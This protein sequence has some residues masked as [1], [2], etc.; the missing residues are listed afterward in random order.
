[1]AEAR[2]HLS[3]LPSVGES[4]DPQAMAAFGA[5]E[6]CVL[7]AEGMPAEALAAARRALSVGDQVGQ[8][9]WGVKAAFQE[10][11]EAALELGDSG[12]ARDLL[13]MLDALAPGSVAPFLLAQRA[14]FH[15][16][17]GSTRAGQNGFA[18]AAEILRELG[19]PFHHA[20]V[21]LEH[22]E[23]LEEQERAEDAAPLREE[24]HEAF[25]RLGA[26]PWLARADAPDEATSARSRARS[27]PPA[28]PGRS[29]AGRA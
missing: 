7:R 20:V 22:A 11:L 23:A 12:T 10:A 17:L 16:R 6:A 5:T 3:R 26:A 2:A 1:V 21:L 25:E 27:A 28:S 15:A 19:T 8:S 24:A 4:H 14:R 9:H 13:E 29:R 18:A